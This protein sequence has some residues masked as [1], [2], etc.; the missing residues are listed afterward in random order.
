M[1]EYLLKTE[2]GKWIHSSNGESFA[3]VEKIE[4]PEGAECCTHLEDNIIFWNGTKNIRLNESDWFDISFTANDYIKEYK[5]AK[6]I[7]Q[8]EPKYKEFLNKNDNYN[9]VMLPEHAGDDEKSGLIEVPGGQYNF[10]YKGGV[11]FVWT[12]KEANDYGELLWQRKTEKSEVNCGEVGFVEKHS[13]YFKDFSDCKKVD[14]Y[15]VL[16][17]FDLVHPCQQHIAKKVLCAGNRGHKD[18]LRDIQ[19]IIDTAE[20]WKEMLLEDSIID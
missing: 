14:V 5:S 20:R 16:D 12:D 7:W 8:R 11:D 6:I 1:K 2:D 3:Y 4:I 19:D 10:C 18:L 9:L 13:H 17:R 15:R